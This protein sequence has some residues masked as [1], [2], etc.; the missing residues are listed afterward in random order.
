MVGLRLYR[1]HIGII[2]T[3]GYCIKYYQ[4]YTPGLDAVF[5]FEK[6]AAT[7]NNKINPQTDNELRVNL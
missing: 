3:H 1:C 4:K 6:K 5:Q 7:D 2:W